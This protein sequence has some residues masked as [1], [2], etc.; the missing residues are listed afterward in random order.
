LDVDGDW[1]QLRKANLAARG[2]ATDLTPALKLYATNFRSA[3]EFPHSSS[4]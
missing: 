1:G 2:T 4:K 3:C